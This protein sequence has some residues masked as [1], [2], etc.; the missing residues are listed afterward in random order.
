M[1]MVSAN[2]HIMNEFT[3]HLNVLVLIV[4]EIS[5]TKKMRFVQFA[6]VDHL[7]SR[8]SSMTNFKSIKDLFIM[9]KVKH[10]LKKLE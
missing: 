2:M 9:L 3:L 4:F 5:Q 7:L 1:L 6:L 8:G 10:I